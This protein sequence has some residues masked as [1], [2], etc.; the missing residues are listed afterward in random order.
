MGMGSD[1]EAWQSWCWGMRNCRI[2]QKRMCFVAFLPWF[3][4]QEI[5][6]FVVFWGGV[7]FWS[8]SLWAFA[9]L[10]HFYAVLL[11]LPCRV[12]DFLLVRPEK[13][14]RPVGGQNLTWKNCITTIFWPTSLESES[15]WRMYLTI[16][17]KFA[18]QTAWTIH[19]FLMMILY[20][21]IPWNKTSFWIMLVDFPFKSSASIAFC[22]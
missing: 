1:S 14:L 8:F 7:F 18:I 22:P 2:T 6:T 13:T 21:Y 16:F 9:T 19:Q 10:S 3:M 11:A 12:C 15:A 4:I 5:S 20:T 17:F